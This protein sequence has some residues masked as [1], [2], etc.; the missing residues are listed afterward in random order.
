[1]KLLVIASALAVAASGAMA[2]SMEQ[3][4]HGSA[5]YAG[6]QSRAVKALSHDEIAGYEQ[7]AGMGFAKAAELNG[8]PGP[9]H[10]LEN[11]A[12]LELTP[13][14]REAMQSLLDRHKREV[15]ALGAEVVRLE[16]ELDTR[17]AHRHV[18]PEVIDAKTA[19]IAAAQARVRASHLRTHLEAT[20]I[21]TPGQ[22]ARYNALRGYGG[23]SS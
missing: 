14:Q 1:M 12:E 21:L 13:A 23:S 11:A 10:V 9:A 2:Q 18:T 6:Q 17:F 8:Y 19:E 16:R 22:V 4:R 5:P 20:A 15:K 3:H 7:G